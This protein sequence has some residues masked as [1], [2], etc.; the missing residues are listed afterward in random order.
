MSRRIV[1]LAFSILCC[2]SCGSAIARRIP[3]DTMAR[4]YADM[5]IADQWFLN[6]REERR[7]TDTLAVYEPIM[8]RYGY[9]F[10]DYD[11]TVKWYVDHPDKLLKVVLAARDMIEDKHQQFEKYLDIQ[12]ANRKLEEY[13]Q[14]SYEDQTFW[15]ALLDSINYSINAQRRDSVRTDPQP[16]VGKVPGDKF[17]AVEREDL[18]F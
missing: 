3:K 15:P 10:A 14:G 9:D 13:L 6:N 17:I 4:I 2:V 1:I 18:Q 11:K 5:Y 16:Q 12:E 7:T 8:K